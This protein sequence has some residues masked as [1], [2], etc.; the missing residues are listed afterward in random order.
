MPAQDAE[1]AVTIYLLLSRLFHL[2]AY[3][4]PM[5]CL[6]IASRIRAQLCRGRR[7]RPRL[8]SRSSGVTPPLDSAML[9]IALRA[10]DILGLSRQPAA[11]EKTR[12]LRMALEVCHH[13]AAPLRRD[14]ICA[15][16]RVGAC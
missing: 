14:F 16:T 3:A 2:A 1:A 6:E 7:G 4:R 9:F 8:M 15:I 5:A 12:A 10:L 13:D 11:K